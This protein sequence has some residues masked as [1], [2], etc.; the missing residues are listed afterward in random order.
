MRY[1][2]FY[3]TLLISN[4]KINQTKLKQQIDHAISTYK[5]KYII[6]EI[7]K[8]KKYSNNN[9]LKYGI[10]TLMISAFVIL[11][12]NRV[13]NVKRNEVNH[14]TILDAIAEITERNQRK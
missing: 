13:V 12:K 2:S 14:E 9:E 5:K 6:N 11:A 4:N 10:L 7:K 3:R 1:K 8:Q